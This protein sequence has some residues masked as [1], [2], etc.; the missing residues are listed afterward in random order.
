MGFVFQNVGSEKEI[1]VNG[2][3]ANRLDVHIE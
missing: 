1:S 2:N 3:D